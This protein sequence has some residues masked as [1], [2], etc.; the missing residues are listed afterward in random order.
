MT[1]RTSR[2]AVIAP[3]QRPALAAISLN[4]G[5]CDSIQSALTPFGIEANAARTITVSMS[6]AVAAITIAVLSTAAHAA[7]ARP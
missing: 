4:L 3:L 5:G 7:R 6:I 1:F 2:K